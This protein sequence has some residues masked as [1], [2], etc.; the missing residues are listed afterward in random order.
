M[1]SQLLKTLQISLPL[2][3]IQELIIYGLGTLE[4]PGAVHIRYQLALAC[5]L[6]TL[7]PNLTD[8]PQSFDP[9]YGPHDQ[10]VLPLLGIEI[11][12]QNEEGRRIARCPTFFFMP[13][14]EAELTEN[15][16]EANTTAGTLQNIIILGNS[17]KMYH[18][19]WAMPGLR[20]AQQQRR[21]PDTLLALVDSGRVSEKPIH[22]FDFPVTAAF[23]DMS[24]H[25][26]R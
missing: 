15:L 16:L 24:L 7:L 13:H 10:A 4:Q 20:T 6:V 3:S 12:Q 5:Q 14:C 17:F 2:P 18:E 26:F 22:E 25:T 8:P 1:Y 11:I 21:R 9:V 23:N 19:R